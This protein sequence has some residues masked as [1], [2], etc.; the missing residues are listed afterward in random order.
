MDGQFTFIERYYFMAMLSFIGLGTMGAPM[1]RNLCAA[2]HTVHVHDVNRE[3]VDVLVKESGALPL[4]RPGD[5]SD[6]DAVI[7][8][9]PNSEIV[10]GVLGKLDDP[11]SLMRSLRPGTLVVDMSSSKPS[12]TREAAGQLAAAGLRMVDAP[13]SGGPRKAAT[14]ELTIMVGGAEADVVE[15]RPILSALGTSITHTGPV[16]SAHALKS[17][18]N[19][20]SAIGLVGALEVLAV[21]RKFGLDPQLMLDV[22]NTSTGRNHSTE[23]KISQQVL[24]GEWSV[25]FSLALTVKDVATALDLAISE[26]VDTPVSAAAVDVCQKALARLAPSKPDQSEIAKYI[27]KVNAF[28]YR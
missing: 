9:L 20:L 16:G 23:V 10:A 6:V 7:L 13:V 12:A 27:E 26:G 22:I 28:T 3:T 4:S 2:Q 17:L 14:G 1:V 15:V 19:L 25:G 8:M 11:A 21:G 24:S 18:N 5:V